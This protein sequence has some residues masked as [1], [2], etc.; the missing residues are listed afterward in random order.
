MDELKDVIAFLKWPDFDQA[1][2]D[3]DLHRGS[4]FPDKANLRRGWT[5]AELK[6]ILQNHAVRNRDGCTLKTFECVE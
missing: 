1:N 4:E 5:N 6:S 2:I 3:T